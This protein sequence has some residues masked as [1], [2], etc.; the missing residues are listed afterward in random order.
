[1]CGY[2]IVIFYICA[3]ELNAVVCVAG[4]VCKVVLKEHKC[5]LCKYLLLKCNTDYLNVKYEVFWH[6]KLYKHC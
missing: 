4:F 6:F 2:P 1:M 5:V 3:L